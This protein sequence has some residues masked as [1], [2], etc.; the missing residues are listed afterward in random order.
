MRDHDEQWWEHYCPK[1][2]GTMSFLKTDACD[3]CGER[4]SF[5]P[6]QLLTKKILP[7]DIFYKVYG[8]ER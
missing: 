2:R 1:Q 3:W 7:P 5:H 8:N 6:Q 4:Y